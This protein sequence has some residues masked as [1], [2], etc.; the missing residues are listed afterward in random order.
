MKKN[1][2]FLLLL[3][4]QYLMAFSQSPLSGNS[5]SDM[6]GKLKGFRDGKSNISI[7]MD[8]FI[9]ENY[10]KH[11][12]Y[13]QKDPGVMGYRIRIFRDSGTDA[14]ERANVV[15]SNFLLK[16]ED[17]DAELK[18]VENI[19]WVVYVGNFRTRS[20]VLKLF[21]KVKVDFPYSFIV[22]QKISVSDE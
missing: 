20:E 21:N 7:Y 11:I 19:D 9:E 6:L 5:Q 17:I 4:F 14:K 1:A 13:N 8:P 10:Y 22:S 2:L 15:R 3:G 12:L 18:Y 16:F